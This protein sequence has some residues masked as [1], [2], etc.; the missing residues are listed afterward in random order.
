MARRP[1][2]FTSRHVL[3]CLVEAGVETCVS[4]QPQAERIDPVGLNADDIHTDLFKAI[5]PQHHCCA[6]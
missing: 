5:D 1:T 3:A 6:V 2:T 4:L